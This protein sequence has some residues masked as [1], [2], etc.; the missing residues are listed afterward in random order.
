MVEG[1]TDGLNDGISDG[2]NLSDK[3]RSV[4][5]AIKKNNKITREDLA[6]KTGYSIATVDRII[7]SLKKKD[8]IKG[9]MSKKNGSWII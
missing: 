3:E 9:K 4:L 5:A 8:V 1:I 7:K 6:S 2:S